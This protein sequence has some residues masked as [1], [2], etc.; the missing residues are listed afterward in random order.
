ML[1]YGIWYGMVWYGI[2]YGIWYGTICA[3]RVGWFFG[4]R[5]ITIAKAQGASQCLDAH[6]RT[7]TTRREFD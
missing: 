7:G 6:V 4:T 1:W 5:L 2:W 3:I